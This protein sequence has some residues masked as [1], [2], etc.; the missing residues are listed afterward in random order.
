MEAQLEDELELKQG[1]VVKITHIIDKDWMRW[2]QSSP[3]HRRLT[4]VVTSQIE[5]RAGKYSEI[6]YKGKI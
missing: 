5:F 1:T 2:V 4:S 6:I 3:V